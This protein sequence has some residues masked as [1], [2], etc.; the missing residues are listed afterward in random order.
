MKSING[1]VCVANRG[2]GE[3]KEEKIFGK[4]GERKIVSIE[5]ERFMVY[6]DIAEACGALPIIK[7]E[8]GFESVK[9]GY[10]RDV[11]GRQEIEF[12]KS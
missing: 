7:R 10:L 3:S 2:E 1:Y 12:L 11:N 4:N 9:V 8:L 6:S 5:N